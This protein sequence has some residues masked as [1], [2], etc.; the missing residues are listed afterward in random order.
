MPVLQAAGTEVAFVWPRVSNGTVLL[1]SAQLSMLLE[2]IEWRRPER[3]APRE[4]D[5]KPP[6]LA[7]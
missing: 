1:T 4:V 2:G 7:A 5:P 6:P 3:T